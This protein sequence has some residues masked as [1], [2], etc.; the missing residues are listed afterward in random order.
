MSASRCRRASRTA[1]AAASCR[2]LPDRPR[3]DAPHSPPSRPPFFHRGPSPLARLAFFGAALDRAAVR[4][5]ALPLPRGRAAGRGR[6]RSIRCSARCSCP[7]RRSREV[8]DVLRLEARARRGERRAEGAPGRAR[9]RGAGRGDAR[10]PRTSGCKALLDIRG[11]FAAT[12]TAVEVLY[13]GRDRSRRSSSSTR[14]RDAGI[15]ARRGGDRRRRRRRPG[16]ARVPVHGGGDARHRQ[17]PRGA[18]EGRAQRRAQRCCS[19]PAPAAR[20]SCASWRPPPTSQVGDVLVT[21]GID[22]TYPPGLAVAQGRRRRARHRARCSRGSRCSRWRASTAAS[23][24]WCSAAPPALP[25]RPEEPAERR[26]REEVAANR[27]C[28]E[29]G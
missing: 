16:D 28:G 3:L 5:H 24:C 15:G 26:G 25:P 12:A 13:T 1:S 19:A 27:A 4:R 21:S 8:G 17:G 2:T 9:R 20:R 10:A 6:R 11:R 18:G 7:A 22:G 23:T 14:A 29:G